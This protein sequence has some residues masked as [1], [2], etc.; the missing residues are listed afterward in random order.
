LNPQLQAETQALIRS[1]A[2][3]DRGW[4]RDYLVSGVEDPRVNLQSVLSRHF[5]AQRIA[6]GRFALLQ[7]EELRFAS[8]VAWLRR[9]L[10]RPDG[11][12]AVDGLSR[13]LAR[14]ADNLD[15]LEIPRFVSLTFQGL[16]S[17][18]DGVDIPNYLERGSAADWARLCDR[19]DLFLGLWRNALGTLPAAGLRVFEP[20]C[21]SANDYRFLDQCGLAR[22]LDYVGIDLC[23]ANIENARQLF[24]GVRFMEG[25]VLALPFGDRAFDVCVVHDLFEHLSLEALELALD[26]VGRVTRDALCLGWF[27]LHE[28]MEHVVNRVD[29]Y[30][31]NLL[32][33]PRLREGLAA[34]GFASQWV[35]L[36]TFCRQELRADAYHNPNAYTAI[37]E[38]SGAA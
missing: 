13:A 18:S 15:G 10:A 38:R 33:L 1:W 29:D 37:A 21:G 30:H 22:H 12:D 3:Y 35:H 5:L 23:T 9:V 34:R 2:G 14:G 32:S 6:P 31:A 7:R 36:G 25:N 11:A 8:V 16:P 26:E 20:A 24:P 27:R 19:P 4:L 17:A 28:G